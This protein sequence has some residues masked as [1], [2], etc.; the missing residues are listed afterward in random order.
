VEAGAPRASSL[1]AIT[2]VVVLVSVFAHGVSAT[3]A[4]RWY[5]ERVAKAHATLA[6][7]RESNA[8]G[9]FKGEASD[10]PRVAPEELR[11]WLDGPE[12][13]L[14]L[15]V[16]TR[17]HYAEGDGQIPGSVRVLPDQVKEWAEQ[18]APTM[19]DRPIVAYCT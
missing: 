17:A 11:S 4:S 18:L 6:E 2:G 12:P 14:V 8:A 9:L 7:E 13:P 16:R 10:I 1:L 5:G 19:R 3:P 15:D